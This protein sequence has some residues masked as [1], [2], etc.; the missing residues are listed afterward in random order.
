[1][2]FPSWGFQQLTHGAS[3]DVHG[4][5]SITP[6]GSSHTKSG[7]EQLVASTPFDAAGFQ[8]DIYYARS[9]SSPYNVSYLF[10]LAFGG[11]GSETIFLQNFLVVCNYYGNRHTHQGSVFV[12][13]PIPAGTRISGRA[14][15]SSVTGGYEVEVG[16]LLLHGSIPWSCARC[17]TLGADTSDTGGLVVDPGGTA[18]TAGSWVEFSASIGSTVKYIIA[19]VSGRNNGVMSQGYWYMQIGVGSASSEQILWGSSFGMSNDMDMITPQRV[20]IPIQIAAGQRIAVRATSSITD[21][22]DRL[23]DVV[24]YCFH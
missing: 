19:V 10:D 24:L 11:S 5:V 14:Q 12:P 1:M 22:T 8:L 16:V 7:Y 13:I 18:H 3:L 23:A 21:A 20:A 6:S 2:D 9:T 4:W 17:T 15:S